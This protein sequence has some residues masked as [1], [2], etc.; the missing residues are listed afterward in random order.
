MTDWIKHDGG[1]Q[2]VADNVWV[3]VVDPYDGDD[4]V[5]T[6]GAFDWGGIEEFTVLNQHLIDAAR[7]E[8]IRLGLKAAHRAVG[9][10]IWVGTPHHHDNVIMRAEATI[11]AL[12]PATIAREEAVPPVRKDHRADAAADAFYVEEA[13]R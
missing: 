4:P 1:P 12:D 5:G 8:G 7:E 6:A 10:M 9:E 3:E 11:M 13:A 2:P